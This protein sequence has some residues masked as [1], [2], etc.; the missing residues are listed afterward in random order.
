MNRRQFIT[1]AGAAVLLTGC[2]DPPGTSDQNQIGY[3]YT[4]AIAEINSALT[5]SGYIVKEPHQGWVA[6]EVICEENGETVGR[7]MRRNNGTYFFY[8]EKEGSE[9]G[10]GFDAD[11]VSTKSFELPLKLGEYLR[12]HLD[13]KPATPHTA[14]KK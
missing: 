9:P 8:A 3:E 13:K 14:E 10:I 2:G 1:A 4:R 7:I 5:G 11:Y 12:T 6:S